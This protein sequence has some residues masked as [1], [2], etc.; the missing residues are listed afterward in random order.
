MKIEMG[1][2]Y[3]NIM[4]SCLRRLANISWKFIRKVNG[5][6]RGSGSITIWI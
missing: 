4:N 5:W 2:E 6:F 3:E 1:F